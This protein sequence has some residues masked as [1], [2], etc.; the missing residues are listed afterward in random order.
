MKWMY[1]IKH[2]NI[3]Y[4]MTEKEPWYWP[5]TPTSIFIQPLNSHA[6][7]YIHR[8]YT[9]TYTQ[10]HKKLFQAGV[11]PHAFNPI[12]EAERLCLCELETILVYLMSSRPASASTKSLSQIEKGKTIFSVPHH[13][14][15]HICALLFILPN[16]RQGQWK[17][18]CHAGT[19][20]HALPHGRQ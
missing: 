4:R 13:P 6:Y 7:E 9:N 3:K 18:F 2:F 5:L 17:Y 19:W 20:T 10:S 8:P 12:R 14:H 16:L 15:M 1:L 11:M